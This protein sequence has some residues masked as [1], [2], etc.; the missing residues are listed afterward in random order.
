MDTTAVL[1]ALL[2]LVVGA[3]LGALFVRA[4]A[5]T[6]I[7]ERDAVRAERD[8]LAEAK[9][10]TEDQ[11][12]DA[13]QECARLGA[14]LAHATTTSE[15][16]LTFLRD[17][18]QR[19]TQEFERLA[20]AALRQ[21]R[22]EFLQLAG[23]RL[24][25]SEER[26]KAELEQRR[27]AVEALVKPLSEHL[28]KVQEHAASLE[29]SR[30]E[31]Y[32]E[33][34]EQ[35]K[36]M[37]AT[38][39]QLRT[40]T[41]QLVAALR[42]PQVRG[43]WGEI[44]LRRVVESAGMLEHVDFSEQESASTADGNLRPDLV[45]KLAGG[46]QVVIDSKVSF[47]GYLEAMEA[48]DDTTHRTRLI[49]HARH[50]K[51]HIDSLSAKKYWDQFTPTPEFVIMFVP[52]EVFLNAALE[53]DPTLLEHAFNHNVVIATPATL[54]AMLRTVAYTWRQDALAENAQQVLD[55]GKELH[56]RLS[57]M[58]THLAKLGRQLD[59]AVKAYNDGVSSLESRVF[60]TARKMAE[61][62]VVSTELEPP[63]QIE[64][65]ARQV[66][67]PELMASADDALIAIDDLDD[68]RYGID[69]RE[70]RPK[71]RGRNGTTG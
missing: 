48:R 56:S 27:V 29:R 10:H 14:Q 54:V 34:R 65:V 43:R 68:A 20:A 30:T 24:A 2:A 42:A 60:V 46:K 22:D 51:T 47:N 38:S 9:L 8:A 66:Q 71:R 17:E 61:L 19:L 59:G 31:A 21:N 44:Q 11:R 57:T 58:G 39:E 25:T 53:K 5:A 62:K 64:R 37:S 67:A 52:A 6:A 1:L 69:N 23:E 7:A 16:K 32:A 40:E 28:G 35:V 70:G 63:A 18:Q 33:L 12:R 3:A 26:A 55:L 15:E 36:G 50:L 41:S 13:E 45:V 49:A 4:R